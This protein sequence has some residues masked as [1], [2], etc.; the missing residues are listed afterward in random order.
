V[1]KKENKLHYLLS[2][3]ILCASSHCVP[4][5]P[6]VTRRIF[7]WTQH[8]FIKISNLD[9]KFGYMFQLFMSHHQ[10]EG[11]KDV[12]GIATVTC[13]P[14]PVPVSLFITKSFEAIIIAWRPQYKVRTTEDK[15]RE[16]LRIPHVI[17]AE[18]SKLWTIL[19][20]WRSIRIS[21]VPASI[22]KQQIQHI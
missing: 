2:V 10:A 12:W 21:R 22:L 17:S 19:L 1:R 4:I 15:I 11:L 6:T 13:F 16:S 7:S 14:L 20:E 5:I 8:L 9:L 3:S 18:T